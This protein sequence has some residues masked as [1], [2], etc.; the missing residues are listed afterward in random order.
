MLQ[1]VTDKDRAKIALSYRCVS[2]TDVYWGKLKNE[3]ITFRKVNLYENHLENT[4][5]DIALKGRQYTVQ[6]ECLAKNEGGISVIKKRW[7]G[8]RG[9]GTACQPDM[10]VF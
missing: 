7:T 10:Q 2:L 1:A 3:K 6:N 9:K 4:F 8:C 5:I